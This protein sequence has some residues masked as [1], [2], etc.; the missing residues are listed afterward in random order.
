[1]ILETERLLVRNWIAADLEHYLALAK[2][3]G[4][5]CF[6]PPGYFLVGTTQQA[7]QKIRDKMALFDE[8]GLGKFPI[9]LKASREFIGTCGLEPFDLDAHAEIELGYRLC[10]RHWGQGYATEA[11]SVVLRYGFDQ[12]G[13][14]RIMAFALGENRASLRVLEKLGFRYLREFLHAGLPHRLFVLTGLTS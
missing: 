12:L 1:M 14:R 13:W 4:Y 11:A 8:Q 3:V 5:N 7:E 2:D 10:L 9:F 6:S